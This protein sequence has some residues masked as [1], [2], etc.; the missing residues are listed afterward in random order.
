MHGND[1]S[2]APLHIPTMWFP[3]QRAQSPVTH[4]AGLFSL[5]QP[6]LLRT[7]GTGVPNE[8]IELMIGTTITH[9]KILEKLG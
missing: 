9:Y 2:Q 3:S 1:W 4:L 6:G 7:F 8:N 5:Y